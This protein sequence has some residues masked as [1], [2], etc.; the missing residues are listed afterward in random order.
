MDLLEAFIQLAPEDTANS[1][2]E[3]RVSIHDVKNEDPGPI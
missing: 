2:K 3:R 1:F